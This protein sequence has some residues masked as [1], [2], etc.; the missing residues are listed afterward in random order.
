MQLYFNVTLQSL[1][2]SSKCSLS[3]KFPHQNRVC[4]SFLPMYATFPVHLI[5]ITFGEEHKL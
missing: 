5:Q 3:S 2:R 1:P 4:I